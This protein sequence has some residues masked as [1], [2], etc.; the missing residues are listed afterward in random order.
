MM[1]KGRMTAEEAVA[2]A[3]RSQ[4]DEI[5]EHMVLLRG[6]AGLLSFEFARQD[7]ALDVLDREME[8]LFKASGIDRASL[9]LPISK[10]TVVSLE[11]TEPEELSILAALPDLSLGWAAPD[12]GSDWNTYA[13][14]IDR[15]VAD[16]EIVLSSDPYD[17]LLSRSQRDLLERRIEE[18]FTLR[19]ADCDRYDYMIAGTCG[20]IGGLVDIL[21]V[22]LPGEGPLTKV[23]DDFADGVVQ[24][25]AGVVGWKGPRVNPNTGESADPLASA[26]GFLERNFQINYDQSTGNGKNGVGG[27]FA[28]STSNHHLKSIGHWPDLFGLVYSIIDQFTSQ[29]HFVSDGKVIAIDTKT[30]ELRG[31]TFAAKVFAGFVNWLGHLASD[32]AGSSGGRGAPDGGRG[33]GIPMPFY[34]LLQFLQVGEF[35]QH[36][37]T[38]ATVAVKVFEQGYDLR[39]GLAMSIPVAITEL[40]TRLMWTFKRRFSQGLPWME[41]LPS[42]SQPELR[43][44]LLVGHGTL[45]LMD[46]VDAG[47]RSGGELVQFM[48]RANIV[49]WT[50]F[51][52]LAVKELK[53]CCQAGRLDTEAVDRYLEDEYLRML[54]AAGSSRR[55]QTD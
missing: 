48:L 40:L 25:F 31:G 1:E 55:H 51:G 16:R 23:A 5:G 42:P 54:G 2:V 7:D 19:N 46:G 45:C 22:G 32:M 10:E 35:G 26:I 29:A 44:M 20:F 33:S 30:F 37:Q 24:R 38:F 50:R 13:V 49:A 41:C 18:E 6:H 53:A 9:D 21:F 4:L 8:E 52:T 11:V 17:R 34:G 43:R 15:F 3:Q 28:M 39:H 27:A 47:V 36:R 14:E 12:A